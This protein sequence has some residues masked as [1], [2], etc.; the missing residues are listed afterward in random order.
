MRWKIVDKLGNIIAVEC[1]RCRGVFLQSDASKGRK[2]C[3]HCKIEIPT[4][5]A[6]MQGTKEIPRGTN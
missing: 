2:H 3:P 4:Y 6:L 1:A 5:K